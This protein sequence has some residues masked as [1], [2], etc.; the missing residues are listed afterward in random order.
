MWNI[1]E[2]YKKCLKCKIFLNC[3]KQIRTTFRWLEKHSE[4]KRTSFLCL[5]IR[6][7]VHITYLFIFVSKVKWIV[8]YVNANERVKLI[9]RAWSHVKTEKNFCEKNNGINAIYKQTWNIYH[10]CWVR[11]SNRVCTWNSDKLLCARTPNKKQH[12]AECNAFSKFIQCIISCTA[13]IRA[14]H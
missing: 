1:I 10:T 12:I 5:S 7:V 3:W 9:C 14:A 6:C 2:I 4:Q 13:S 8:S 11:M